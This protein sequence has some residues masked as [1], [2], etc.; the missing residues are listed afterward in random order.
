MT[1]LDTSPLI[2]RAKQ[3]EIFPNT[4]SRAS[5]LAR[6]LDRLPAGKYIVMVEKPDIPRAK[7]KVVIQQNE[8]IR[9]MEL[10]CI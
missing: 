9:V 2:V 3:E 4:S 5:S 10:E 8:I 6:V 1:I 7:W